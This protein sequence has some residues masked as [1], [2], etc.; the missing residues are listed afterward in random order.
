[1]ALMGLRCVLPAPTTGAMLYRDLTKLKDE[2]RESVP[3]PMRG[4]TQLMPALLSASPE[5]LSILSTVL[6][7]VSAEIQDCGVKNPKA[8]SP[9]TRVQPQLHQGI[10][11]AHSTLSQIL[12]APPAPP[13]WPRMVGNWPLQLIVPF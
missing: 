7:S 12:S 2:I 9:S 6:G 1:M 13:R 11:P 8:L 4:H 10:S 5:P 3:T